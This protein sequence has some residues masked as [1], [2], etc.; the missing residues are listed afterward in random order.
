MDR[1]RVIAVGARIGRLRRALVAAEDELATLLGRAR[2]KRPRRPGLSLNIL[3]V[4]V[5]GPLTS[6]EIAR[7]AGGRLASVRPLLWRLVRAGD[8]VQVDARRPLRFA[9]VAKR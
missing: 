5:H 3:R 8:V 4:L 7:R 1:E 9:L 6:L 2:R